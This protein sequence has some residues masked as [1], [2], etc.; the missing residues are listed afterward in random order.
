MYKLVL[1][2]RRFSAVLHASHV[3]DNKTVVVVISD[4]FEEETKYTGLCLRAM[5]EQ[6]RF[7]V[8]KAYK[9]FGIRQLYHFNQA[10]RHINYEF[11]TT[12]LQLLLAVSPFTHF[13]YKENGDNRLL[14]ICR[15]VAG[16]EKRLVYKTVGESFYN[17]DVEEY[18]RKVQ[19]I[20]KF[21]TMDSLIRQ[22]Y[23]DREYIMEDV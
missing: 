3:L 20:S 14:T 19:A 12:K 5:K 13:F 21:V 15:K 18:N 11:I 16:V 23:L 8:E 4:G 7:E 22:S 17:L 1:S 9:V 2:Q 6:R 10:W